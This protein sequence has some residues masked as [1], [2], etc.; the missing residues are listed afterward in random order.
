MRA[1]MKKIHDLHARLASETQEVTV[2]VS[3][4]SPPAF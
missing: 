1:F 4:I 2:D 3:A